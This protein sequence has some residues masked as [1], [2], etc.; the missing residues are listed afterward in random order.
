MGAVSWPSRGSRR[1]VGPR[2]SDLRTKR[3]SMSTRLPMTLL[4]QTWPDAAT[5]LD[6]SAWILGAVFV[7]LPLSVS[8]ASILIGVWMVI[9]A[10]SVRW[11]DVA[12]T[13]RNP[14]ILGGVSLFGWMVLAIGWSEADPVRWVDELE[15]Y[16][17]LL[18]VPLVVAVCSTERRLRVAVGCLVTV[19]LVFA[20]LS[21]VSAL[22]PGG[23]LPGY[24]APGV[25]AH[26]YVTQTGL[27]AAAAF[28]AAHLAFDR[29][30]ERSSGPSFIPLLL[31]F[32]TI[33]MLASIGYVTTA[34]S[35]LIVVAA[36]VLLFGFQRFGLKG[37]AIAVVLGAVAAAAVWTTSPMLRDRVLNIEGEITRYLEADEATSA[38]TRLE[39]WSKGV[40]IFQAAPIIGHGTGSTLQLYADKATDRATT[41]TDDT[42]NQVL[43]IAIPYGSVGVALLLFYWLAQLSVFRGRDL[44]S[45]LGQGL[46]VQVVITSMFHS[47]MWMFIPGWYY[48]LYLGLLIAALRLGKEALAGQP[49]AIGRSDD[50]HSAQ[51]PS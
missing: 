51:D 8:V 30:S 21:W 20:A 31:A 40:E 2:L 35:A 45:W 27:F 22:L 28:A 18:S 14:V 49:V 11:S 29:W 43:Q 33:A 17:S 42:H 15:S 24:R 44:I 46:L 5:R 25:V 9:V 19:V 23:L 16:V 26:D 10:L 41:V 4:R 6:R 47:Q 13:I 48:A 34:R 3:L 7:A 36:L 50:P 12:A 39:L 38:G 1:F 37:L 32:V